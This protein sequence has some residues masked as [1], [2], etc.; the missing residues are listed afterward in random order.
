VNYGLVDTS[1]DFGP[2][3][4]T[5]YLWLGGKEKECFTIKNVKPG[6]DITMGVESHKVSDYIGVANI[7]LTGSVYGK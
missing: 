2:Y 7:I 1:K 3:H 4:G 6:T 5:S